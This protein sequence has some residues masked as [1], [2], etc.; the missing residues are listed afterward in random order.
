MPRSTVFLYF[1]WKYRNTVSTLKNT[2][3]DL[4]EKKKKKKDKI[5]KLEIEV[6]A[7]KQ[8]QESY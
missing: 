8:L 5:N 2:G 4:F 7:V 3:F 1:V 6:N